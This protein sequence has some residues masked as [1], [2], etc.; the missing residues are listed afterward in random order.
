MT[1]YGTS[2][3]PIA[4]LQTN[5]AKLKK[6]IKASKARMSGIMHEIVAHAPKAT[7]R[8]QGVGQIVSNTM[9]IF[10]GVR[11]GLSII[12]AVRGMFGRKRSRRF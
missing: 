9:A 5:K 10:E 8:I 12:S 6:E 3:N 4:A 11:I 1:N 7:S 2:Q